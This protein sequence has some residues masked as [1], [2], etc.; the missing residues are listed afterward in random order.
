MSTL[1][2]LGPLSF[3]ALSP[4]VSVSDPQAVRERAMMRVERCLFWNMTGRILTVETV[5][6][7]YT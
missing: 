2:L 7:L 3:A 1:V 5:D 4:P 6:L